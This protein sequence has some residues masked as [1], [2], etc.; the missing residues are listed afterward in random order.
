MALRA[1][2]GGR[3]SHA[4]FFFVWLSLPSYVVLHVWTRFNIHIRFARGDYSSYSHH[5]QLK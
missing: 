3:Q 2:V 5:T 1:V 4:W